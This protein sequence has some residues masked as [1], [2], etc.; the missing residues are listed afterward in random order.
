MRSVTKTYGEGEASVT[1]L[2][3]FSVDVE[4]GEMVAVMGTSGSGKSTLLAIAGALLTPTSGTVEVAGEPLTRMGRGG[5]A[6]LR[7]ERIGF[8]F[9]DFNLLPALTV[10][11]NVALPLDLAGASRATARSEARRALAG[12]G[13]RQ[14]SGNY[15]D[16]LSGGQQ[17]RVAIA[18]ATVGSRQLLLADEPTGALDSVTGDH[19]LEGLRERTE[20]GA[21]VVLVTHDARHAAWA[22]RILYL[23]DG[24]LVDQARASRPEQLLAGQA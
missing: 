17:Q 19:V 3:D 20:E 2:N 4:A 11:E 5:L 12:V 23:A 18:R 13:M 10:L 7:R 14:R 1:A 21:A 6:R 9:Q 16:E 15:P 8:V 22:D 24:R